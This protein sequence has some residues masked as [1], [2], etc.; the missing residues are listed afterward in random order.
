MVL[1][2]AALP[3]HL[4]VCALLG[5]ELLNLSFEEEFLETISSLDNS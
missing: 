3:L 1:P 2:V 5:I 4:P